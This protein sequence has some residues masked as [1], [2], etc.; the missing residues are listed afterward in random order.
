MLKFLR[1]VSVLLLVTSFQSRADILFLDLN[2][3]PK[4]VE[5]AQAA[6]KKRGE[7]VIVIP[8]VTTEMKV[9]KQKLKEAREKA[10][11][12]FYRKGCTVGT[13]SEKCSGVTEKLSEAVRQENEFKEKNQLNGAELSKAI[14][15]LKKKDIKLST[16][17]VSGHDGNGA[18]G[19]SFGDLTDKDIANAFINNPPMGEGI[20]SLALWGCYT[21]NVSSL[22]MYWKRSFPQAEVV[23][24]FDKKGPLGNSPANWALLKDFLSKEKELS[25]IKDQN[26]LRKAL[27]GLDGVRITEAAICVGGIMTNKKASMDLANAQKMCEGAFLKNKSLYTC[28]LNAEKDCPNPPANTDDSDLR[29][30]YESF[31]DY[32]HCAEILPPEKQVGMPS[33]D[34]M[35][36]LI[37]F[38]DVKKNFVANFPLEIANY[39]GLLDKVGAPKELQWGDVQKMS[40]AEIL[41]KLNATSKYLEGKVG[42]ESALAPEF[43]AINK[44]L[45]LGI[46]PV[47]G[48][49]N[50]PFTWVE[51]GAVP[52]EGMKNG[53]ATSS[54]ASVAKG[55]SE[56]ESNRAERLLKAKVDQV[57]KTN[58]A[59]KAQ[60]SDITARELE[61]QKQME[62]GANFRD[63]MGP[64][65]K[66]DEDRTKVLETNWHE[67]SGEIEQY[68][69][70]L[71]S[72]EYASAEGQKIFNTKLDDM[73]KAYAKSAK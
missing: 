10:N 50:V 29:T 44:F 21:A 73:M 23:M 69:N 46:Q 43:T 66:I 58:S 55:R 19:G 53:M 59:T 15:E 64:A 32:V 17:V 54:P 1:G 22:S 20:R 7:K 56:Y 30:F 26:E 16:V 31:Q 60:M 49:L 36:R 52:N 51:A 24:G 48:D 40:R 12:D 68:K 37:H 6:A 28:Y 34:T 72:G 33:G 62:A 57:M 13:S 4:E 65:Q 18:F 63:I 42:E 5:A 2:G 67:I 61:I 3:N 25:K 27:K 45:T 35:I 14:T 47:L 39:N 11:D 8:N 71:Q 70:Q 9:K 38:A 41:A